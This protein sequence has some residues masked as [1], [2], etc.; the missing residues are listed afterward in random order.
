VR[1]PQACGWDS[2]ASTGTKDQR[3]RWYREARGTE[4]S[5]RDEGSLNILIVPVES[6]E[7]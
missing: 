6:R 4:A 7:T 1:K 2:L 3:G 5:G